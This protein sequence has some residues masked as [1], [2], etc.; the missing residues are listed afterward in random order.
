MWGNTRGKIV[1]G[2]KI[3]GYSFTGAMSALMNNLG[4]IL[5]K[6]VLFFAPH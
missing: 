6:N 4:G 2:V 1:A 3:G 5:N